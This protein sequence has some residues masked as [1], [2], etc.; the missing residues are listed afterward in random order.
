MAARID[1]KKVVTRVRLME[2]LVIPASVILR[3]LNMI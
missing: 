1:G 3:C 2:E